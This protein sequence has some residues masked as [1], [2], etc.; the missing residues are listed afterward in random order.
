MMKPGQGGDEMTERRFQIEGRDLGYPTMFRDGSTAMGLFAVSAR[1][2]QGLIAES[3]FEVAE[4]APGRGIFSLNCVHYTDSDCGVYEEIALSFFVKKVGG[5]R[6]LPYLSTWAEIL[7][8]EIASYTWVLPVTTRLACEAGIQMWGF[9]KT[10]EQIQYMRTSERAGFDLR[11]DGQDV[12][13][14]SVR[15][16]GKGERCVEAP[17]YS[18]YEGAPHVSI[19]SQKYC[20]V[21][22]QLGGGELRLGDHPLAEQLRSLGLPRRPLVSTWMGGFHFEMSA[23]SKL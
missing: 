11:M 17:V 14:Y 7:R 18:V 3:G 12:L 10:V 20:E 15:A 6:G 5:G 16:R 23:P 2:A 19:L 22:F 9:P 21:G 4:I 13:S 1:A 8:G